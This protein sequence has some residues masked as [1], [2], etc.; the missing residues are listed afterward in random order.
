MNEAKTARNL[1][2]LHHN[3]AGQKV[4]RFELKSERELNVGVDIP[5]DANL[6]MDGFEDSLLDDVVLIV[7]GEQLYAGGVGE[8]ANVAV[9]HAHRG[10]IEDPPPLFRL[11]VLQVAVSAHDVELLR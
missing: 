11:H 2:V 4:F 8:E 1:A 9:A 3:L 5:E 10:E 7:F 6:L